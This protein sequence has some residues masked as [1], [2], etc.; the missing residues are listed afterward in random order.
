[1]GLIFSPIFFAYPCRDKNITLFT[2]VN[3][4]IF[5]FVARNSFSFVK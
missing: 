1:M 2:N 3:V 4:I 5:T